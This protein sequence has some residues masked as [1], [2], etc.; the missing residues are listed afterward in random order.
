MQIL[1]CGVV[2]VFPSVEGRDHD[3]LHEF[4]VIPTGLGFF[5]G[6]VFERFAEVPQH[7][8]EVG[9]EILVGVG[10]VEYAGFQQV[11]HGALNEFIVLA[12]GD[13]S[14]SFVHFQRDLHQHERQRVVDLSRSF[15]ASHV[16]AEFRG[17]GVKHER[18]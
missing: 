5:D 3:L 16:S 2:Q 6:P 18:I 9:E 14:P 12:P 13:V 4:Q 10:V 11:E 1:H 7:L 15:A 8:G 17:R